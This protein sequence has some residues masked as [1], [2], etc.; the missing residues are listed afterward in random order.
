MS[1]K[2]NKGVITVEASLVVPIFLFF[3][4][5]LFNLFM[6]L[7]AEAH[8]HQALAEAA[9]YVAQYSYLGYKKGNME[10]LDTVLLNTQLR[11][12]LGEDFYIERTVKGGKQGILATV[13]NDSDNPKVFYVK[14]SFMAGMDVPVF[15]K[16]YI[17]LT[18]EIKQKK[19]VGYSPDEKSDIYVYITPEQS[20]YH[21]SRS[22]THLSL[23][24][25]SQSSKEK[26]NYT[27]C[28]FCGAAG[29]DSG[30]IYISRTGSVF[31][32]SRT[33]SGLKRTVKRVKKK[34]VG[35]LSPCSRCGI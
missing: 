26:G 8:I 7:F 29:N 18:D 6:L 22:C 4:L 11:K 14:A 24:F 1:H 34:E 5:A 13:K 12:Y 35:G 33:C 10:V 16:F 15:G 28:H 30:E 9:D 21:V 27:P 23:Q 17:C 25:C 31:H 2:K 32:Y 3:M 20:V 19:F